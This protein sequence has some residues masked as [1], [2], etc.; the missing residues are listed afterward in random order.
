MTLRINVRNILRATVATMLLSASF[1]LAA[2]LCIAVIQGKPDYAN[3]FNIIGVSW[4]WPELGTGAFNALLGIVFVVLAG[5]VIYFVM[6]R[7]DT[8]QAKK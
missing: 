6:E 5:V 8:V 7:H 3:M 1:H 4:L 2:S